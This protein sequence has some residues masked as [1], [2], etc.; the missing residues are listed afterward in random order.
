MYML[1][2]FSV[3]S[4]NRAGGQLGSGSFIL[5]WT[6]KFIITDS[7]AVV[8]NNTERSPVALPRFPQ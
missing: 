3:H 7:H 2:A 5:K 6:A 4:V 8:G 1:M